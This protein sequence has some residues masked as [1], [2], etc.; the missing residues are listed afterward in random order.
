MSSLGASTQPRIVLTGAT[1]FVGAVVAETL[2]KHGCAVMALL[3]RQAVIRDVETRCIGDLSQANQLERVLDGAD[4]IVHL[5][6]RAHIMRDS[7]S[8][9]AAAYRAA[10]VEATM[11]LARAAAS[12]GA[13]R[14]VFISSI[15][16]NGEQTLANPFTPADL[17]AP[18]D[19]YAQSKLE[20]ENGLRELE[21]RTGLE[22][23]IIRP[24]LVYGPGVKG[25]LLRLLGAVRKG[26]PL[27]FANID[28]RRS[29]VGVRN[30]A[31]LIQHCITLPAAAGETF[32]VSDGEDISSADLIRRLAT[33]MERRARLFPIP[34]K[35]L[36]TLLTV[37]G[38]DGLWCRAFGSLQVDSAKTRDLLGW[39]PPYTLDAGLDEMTDWYRAR[40]PRVSK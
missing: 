11:R 6:A 34:K 3:R 16:V 28:N 37:I 40:A 20:A 26:A 12:A 19:A 24:P 39:R 32:L 27:P 30:L 35:L 31:D 21:Q 29:L 23:A 7:A 33:R 25:N 2:V 1:G 8:D 18:N 36:R 22:V 4:A 38:R 9:A 17:A 13:R 10:N 14:F 15:K 5:A